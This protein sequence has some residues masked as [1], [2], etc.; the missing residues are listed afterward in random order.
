CRGGAQ[1][2]DARSEATAGRGALFALP[3]SVP[4]SHSAIG[5]RHASFQSSN[6]LYQPQPEGRK[7]GV[8]LPG[9]FKNSTRAQTRSFDKL[10]TSGLSLAPLV[11]SLSKDGNQ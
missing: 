10:R 7:T 6:E 11:L 4:L 5:S 3:G 8:G 1:R 9:P 2:L